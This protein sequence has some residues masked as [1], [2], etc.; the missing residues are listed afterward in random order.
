V[1][2]ALLFRVSTNFPWVPTSGG[3]QFNSTVN[4]GER[5]WQIGF[6]IIVRIPANA[7]LQLDCYNL[8]VQF[9]APLQDE[10]EP[11]VFTFI[12]A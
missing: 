2:I 5:F 9:A 7:E 1:S 8:F 6:G 4:I 11:P 12:P 3:G 10:Q